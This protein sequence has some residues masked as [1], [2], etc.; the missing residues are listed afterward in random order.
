MPDS[1]DAMTRIK[2]TIGDLLVQLA[3]A[4]TKIEELEAELAKL[5]SE[6]PSE[7]NVSELRKGRGVP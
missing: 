4:Q 3:A 5:R 6:I 2:L 1:M 7:D